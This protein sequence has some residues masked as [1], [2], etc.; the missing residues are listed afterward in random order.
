[1]RLMHIAEVPGRT[2]Q[3]ATQVERR[4]FGTTLVKSSPIRDY[5][6]ARDELL[7]AIETWQESSFSIGIA[8]ATSNLGRLE[9]RSGNHSEGRRLLER[10]TDLFTKI[11]S[12]DLVYETRL[13]LVEEA[14][15]LGRCEEVDSLLANVP[16]T[17]TEAAKLPGRASHRARLLGRASAERGNAPAALAL[18]MAAYELAEQAQSLYEQAQ[19]ASSIASLGDGVDREI[20]DKY[21][22]L[23]DDFFDRLG[24]LDAIRGA[25]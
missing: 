16:D 3:R 5:E 14:L 10:A 19:V 9:G 1:V 4:S 15:R 22:R 7:A 2:R 12:W 20:V 17:M 11:G 24:V 18:Y 23:A 21:R 6:G 13:R 8:L 25:I